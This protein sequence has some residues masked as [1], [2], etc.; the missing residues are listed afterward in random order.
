MQYSKPMKITEIMPDR[1]TLC[2]HIFGIDIKRYRQLAQE[3]VVPPAV[4]GNVDILMAASMLIASLRE[5]KE[6]SDLTEERRLKTQVERRIKE[7]EEKKLRGELIARDEVVAELVARIHV[8]KSDLL[9]LDKRLIKY[10]EA[11]EITKKFIRHL[12]GVYSQKRGV[13]K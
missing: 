9:M 3:G 7:L 12:M 1:R 6:E 4:N 10:P 13:F 11:R 2:Q 8:L 5:S